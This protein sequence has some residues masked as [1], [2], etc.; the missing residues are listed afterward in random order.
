VNGLQA[1]TSTVGT[2]NNRLLQV[3]KLCVVCGLLIASC[4]QGVCTTS[5]S[6]QETY[7]N[8]VADA[9]F[10]AEGGRHLTRFPYGVKSMP[11]GI[12][13]PRRVCL[14]SIRNN[15][16]RWE[17]AGKPGDFIEFMGRRY[18]PPNAHPLNRHWVK[19]VNH[20]LRKSHGSTP[21]N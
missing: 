17:A 11:E 7:F 16:R 8:K 2:G 1:K 5:N 20:H 3:F 4:K 9:I 10:V 19:N 21:T 6:A 14:N 13:D 12:S 15:Y 18:C